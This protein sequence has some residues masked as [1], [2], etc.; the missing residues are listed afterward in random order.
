MDFKSVVFNIVFV[1]WLVVI[2]V[3]TGANTLKIDQVNAIRLQDTKV[4]VKAINSI[5]K[6]A[7]VVQNIPVKPIK[8]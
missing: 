1:I 3:L 7:P 2:T 8:K 5:S 4:L 6:K